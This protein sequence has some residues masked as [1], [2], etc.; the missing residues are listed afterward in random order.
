M[1]RSPQRFLPALIPALALAAVALSAAPAARDWPQWRGPN[2]DGVAPETGLLAQWPETGPPLLWQ[3]AGL[4]GGF[5]SLALAGERIFTLGDREGGQHLIAV[6]RKDGK[7]LW[8]TRIGPVWED[9][10]AG[11]RSTPTVDGDRV[12]ALGTEGDLVAVEA[13]TGKEVWRRNLEKDFGGKMMSIWKWTESPTVD[14]DR[15]IV[16]PGVAGALM[17]ALDKKTGKEVW[18]AKGPADLGPKGKDGAG[19]AAVAIGNGGGVKQYVQLIGRGLI[20]VRAADGKL[21]WTYNQVANDVA[22]ISTPVVDG[23][24]VFASTGYQTG[25]V[26]LKLEKAGDGVAA[27]EVYFLAPK[28]FQN[29]HGGFVL[30]GDHLYAGHG[31]NRGMPICVELATGKVA[32]GGEG[33]AIDN[34]GTGSAAVTAADGHLYFRYQ[35]GQVVL[36]EAT[37]A[38]Y[39]QKGSFKIPDV[40]RPSWSHPVVADGK[41]YLREQDNLYV[42]NVKKS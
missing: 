11:P 22:N 32:W 1:H 24:H 27:K 23:D 39:K 18:R 38:G 34:G 17:V 13:A 8:A 40:S 5:S 14:G 25:S 36:I 37:P 41:L 28:T 9:Q 26:L 4:G 42:Y 3:S 16:T 21:L 6:S 29:H 12:Y 20:G 33:N 7:P 10:F 35:N 15:L 2:R 30:L 31:H 19:Y